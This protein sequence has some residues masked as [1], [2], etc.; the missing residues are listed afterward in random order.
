[1]NT[2]LRKPS[3]TLS[4][5][6]FLM[7]FFRRAL[8]VRDFIC[9]R[10][11]AVLRI[12]KSLAANQPTNLANPGNRGNPAPFSMLFFQRSPTVSRFSQSLAANQSSN[13]GNPEQ[14]LQDYH[15]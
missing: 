8:H 10:F 11:P 13:R 14:D 4:M 2:A 15:D 6:T 7:L 3:L 5:T 9:A 12:S 1:M